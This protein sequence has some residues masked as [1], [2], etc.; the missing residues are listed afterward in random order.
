MRLLVYMSY[1]AIHQHRPARL[2]G[3]K[4]IHEERRCTNLSIAVDDGASLLAL[5]RSLHL[6]GLGRNDLLHLCTARCHRAADGARARRLRADGDILSRHDRGRQLE[7]WGILCGCVD[8]RLWVGAVA[9]GGCLCHGT[10]ARKTKIYSVDLI[11]EVSVLVNH[12]SRIHLQPLWICFMERFIE[13]WGKIHRGVSPKPCTTALVE[14]R[15]RERVQPGGNSDKHSKG[16]RFMLR[17]FP[18]P[19]HVPQPVARHSEPNSGTVSTCGSH[20]NGATATSVC[21]AM[22]LLSTNSFF[23]PPSDCTSRL[24]SLSLCQPTVAGS[25]LPQPL[26]CTPTGCSPPTPQHA[27]TCQA[28]PPER[29]FTP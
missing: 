23:L 15:T 21:T 14:H 24:S 25:C 20:K 13:G 18:P 1:M 26:P 22:A 17:R 2:F 29:L 27:Y 3:K 4:E 11:Y 10:D 12:A 8:L 28:R 9:I 16:E 5:L 6:L 7:R 19:Q